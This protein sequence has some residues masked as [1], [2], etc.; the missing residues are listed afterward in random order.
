MS[1]ILL[2]IATVVV[3]VIFVVVVVV[4]VAGQVEIELT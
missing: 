4:V 1:L 3:D 2:E